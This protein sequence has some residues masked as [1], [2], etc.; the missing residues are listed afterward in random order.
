MGR[1]PL[2][3]LADQPSLL[4]ATWPCPVCEGTGREPR[5]PAKRCPMCLGAQVLDFD[6]AD[7]SVIPF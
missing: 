3:A 1:R 2:T 7:R 6:P 4:D 5:D